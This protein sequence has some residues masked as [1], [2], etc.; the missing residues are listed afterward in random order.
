MCTCARTHTHRVSHTFFFFFTMQQRSQPMP[1][2][3]RTPSISFSWVSVLRSLSQ[4]LWHLVLFNKNCNFLPQKCL[5]QPLMGF[6]VT[7]P[8]KGLL[9]LACITSLCQYTHR[10]C[11]S[12]SR[13][14]PPPL[15]S[16]GPPVPPTM[17]GAFLTL[18]VQHPCLL[19]ACNSQAPCY[20]FT[21]LTRFHRQPMA[22]AESVTSCFCSC[23]SN[24]DMSFL[25][26]R[27]STMQCY[28]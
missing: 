15:P 10:Y 22:E 18:R 6:P 20:V 9:H 23:A 19:Y 24:L 25:H 16:E 13:T 26:P 8:C 5:V 11:L 3:T 27:P 14:L 7:S 2:T 4:S 17:A 1:Q 21:R 28:S 12:A